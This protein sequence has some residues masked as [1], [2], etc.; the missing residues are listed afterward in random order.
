MIA[1]LG[2]GSFETF[3]FFAVI[4]SIALLVIAVLKAPTIDDR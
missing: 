3:L 4:T 2:Y 1:L